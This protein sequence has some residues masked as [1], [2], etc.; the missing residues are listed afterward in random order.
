MVHAVFTSKGGPAAALGLRRRRSG[1]HARDPA[2]R[3]SPET[4]ISA[5]PGLFTGL[6]T[7]DGAGAPRRRRAGYKPG[8]L[9]PQMRAAIAAESARLA[10]LDDDIDIVRAVGEWFNAL[11]DA[12]LE[13]GEH[14]LLALGRLRGD[15]WTYSRLIDATG[16]SK[17]R[18]S[19]LV[20]R[21]RQHA[22]RNR[23]SQSVGYGNAVKAFTLSAKSLP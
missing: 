8:E 11:D 6:N 5:R 9:S 2:E 23:S 20:N 14:R 18:I 19:T 4:T 15:G 13:I 17:A 1:R 3:F 16:L 12:I 10:E 21:A 7:L 22:A